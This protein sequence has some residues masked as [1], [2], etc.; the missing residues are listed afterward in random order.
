MTSWIV[1]GIGGKFQ[2]Q[3][4]SFPIRVSP[5]SSRDVEQGDEA[6]ALLER[7]E[8][9]TTEGL[10]KDHVAGGNIIIIII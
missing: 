3:L 6:A 7:L 5:A 10:R 4:K 2:G 8:E 9:L 1:F